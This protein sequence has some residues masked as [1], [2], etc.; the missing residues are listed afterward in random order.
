MKTHCVGSL[1]VRVEQ[2]G[3][4]PG[5]KLKKGVVMDLLVQQARQDKI[6]VKTRRK[7]ACVR[8]VKDTENVILDLGQKLQTRTIQDKKEETERFSRKLS[9][10]RVQNTSL[11]DSEEPYDPVPTRFKKFT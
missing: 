10:E 7:K 3:S 4:E 6:P 11:E 8:F 1:K 9:Q 2:Q 5:R